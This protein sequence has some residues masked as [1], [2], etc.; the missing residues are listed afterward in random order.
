MKTILLSIA[1][2]AIVGAV[3]TGGTTAIFSD[4]ETST[5]NT[6]TAGA[7]DLKIDNDSYYNGVKNDGT[8]WLKAN[9]DD[10]NGP[11]EG[12]K[13]WFFDFKDLKPGDWGEDTISV[14]VND[15]NSWLCADVTL[16]SNQDNGSTEPELNDEVAELGDWT[17]GRGELGDRVSFIAWADDGDNVLETDE[18]VYGLGTLGSLDVGETITTALADSTWNVWTEGNNTPL[19]GGK[20]YYIGKAWC[21]G[22][23]TV[24]AVTPG[25]DND[26]TID[27]GF[28]CD[29]SQENNTTQTDTLTADISFR[30]VQSRNND[31][32]ICQPATQPTTGTLT[33]DKFIAFTTQDSPVQISDFTLTI[34]DSSSNS[35]VVTDEV[36]VSGLAPDIY[37]VSEVYNGDTNFG[38]TPAFSL[39]CTDNS[40]GTGQVVLNAGDNLT[41][42]II[43]TETT[44]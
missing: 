35:Q 37:T 36:S 13:Y 6:F 5:G 15:N 16:T 38:F 17:A 19:D 2:L 42:R 34:T 32:F 30:A 40:D 3:V 33:V 10:G 31:D 27:P 14:H 8:S 25:D 41:C 22:N 20:D 24:D 29:G 9:L 4:S 26:P 21:F 12:G 23:L 39:D 18:Q 28:D 43:N 44:S 11:G 1:T 7:I